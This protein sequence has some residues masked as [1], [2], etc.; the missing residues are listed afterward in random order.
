[1]LLMLHVP[2][3]NTLDFLGISATGIE[4]ICDMNTILNNSG[5]VVV[6]L[7]YGSHSCSTIDN[8]RVQHA[9]S[10]RRH[11]STLSVCASLFWLTAGRAASKN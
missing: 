8:T 5:V 7:L 9:Q 10:R 4:R 11:S 1:M 3:K 6:M 2:V